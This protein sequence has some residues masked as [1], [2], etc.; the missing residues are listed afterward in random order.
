M[1]SRGDS[2]AAPGAALVPIFIE[3][4]PA[5]IAILKFLFE[6]YEGVAVVRTLDRHEAVIV[7]LVSADFLSVAR[8]MLASLAGKVA[9]REIPPPAGANEDWLLQVLWGPDPA[10][11]TAG[12]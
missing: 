10:A 1:S 5:E 4:A 8:G 12:G 2:R 9:F 11:P 7:A 6:S 3:V